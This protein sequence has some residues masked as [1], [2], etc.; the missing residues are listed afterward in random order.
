MAAGRDEI[1][2]GMAQWLSTIVG[3][4]VY[5]GIEEDE[6]LEDGIRRVCGLPQ[7][8]AAELVVFEE[9]KRKERQ[10]D[11]YYEEQKGQIKQLLEEGMTQTK[12]AKRLGISQSY[13]SRVKCGYTDWISQREQLVIARRKKNEE[14]ARKKAL[15]MMGEVEQTP[16]QI[17]EAELAAIRQ[18]EERN[19]KKEG[20]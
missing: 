17:R 2:K 20:E 14:A 6:M 13:V 8:A 3:L 5:I 4:R 18:A 12:I 15:D 10:S 11:E 16:E 19:K 1:V 9:E 7:K